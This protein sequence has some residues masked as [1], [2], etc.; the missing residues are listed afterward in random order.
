MTSRRRWLELIEDGFTRRKLCGSYKTGQSVK[1]T[2]IKESPNPNPDGRRQGQNYICGATGETVPSLYINEYATH[3][4]RILG[5]IGSR[6]HGKTAYLAALAHCLR[7]LSPGHFKALD[8]SSLKHL[9]AQIQDL[10]RGELPGPTPNAPQRP[11]LFS[12]TDMAPLGGSSSLL[13]Y[14]SSGEAWADAASPLPPAPFIHPARDLL[15]VYAIDPKRP[16]AEIGPDMKWLLNQF[17]IRRTG[18]VAGPQQLVVVLTKADQWAAQLPESDTVALLKAHLSADWR[19]GLDDPIHY[20]QRLQLVS[21]ALEAVLES[22]YGGGGFLQLARQHFPLGMQLTAVS[23]LGT[24]PE[25]TTNRLTEGFSPKRVLDPLLW[26]SP[27]NACMERGHP[28]PPRELQARLLNVFKSPRQTAAPSASKLIQRAGILLLGLLA[29]TLPAAYLFQSHLP[30][31]LVEALPGHRPSGRETLALAR[32]AK[33]GDADALRRLRQAAED[34]LAPAQ[35]ELSGLLLYGTGLPRDPEQGA[36][37]VRKA[38]AQGSARGHTYLSDYYFYGQGGYPRDMAQAV[39]HAQLAAKARDPLGLSFLGALQ[40]KA[41]GGLAWDE[42]QALAYVREAAALS[43]PQGWVNLANYYLSGSAGVAKNIEE[44]R[45]L[46]NQAVAENEFGAY[47]ILG[48][49]YLDNDEPARRDEQKALD[50]FR[51]G[52]ARNDPSCRANLAGAYLVGLYGLPKDEAKARQIYEQLEREGIPLV[53]WAYM[54]A[55]GLAGLPKDEKRALKL[56]QTAVETG[57]TA[58]MKT[59]GDYYLN[60]LAGLTADPTEALRWFRLAAERGNASAEVSLG[61]M[62]TEGKGLPKDA[63]AAFQHYRK[64]ADKGDSEG[65]RGVGLAYINGDGVKQDHD[66]GRRW[67]EKSLALGCQPCKNDL[68]VLASGYLWGGLGP[69]KNQVKAREILE[70]LYQQGMPTSDYAYLLFNGLGGV[71]QDEVKAKDIWQGLADQGDA[72]SMTLIGQLYSE[73]KGGLVR[74]DGKAIE[75]WEKASA[76]NWLPADVWL[77]KMAAEGR[78]GL[79]DLT[80]A[81]RF[82]LKAAKGGNVDGME[83]YAILCATGQ[84]VARD[85]ETARLWL[86]EALAKGSNNAKTYLDQLDQREQNERRALGQ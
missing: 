39:Q 58:A 53:D 46:A 19:E 20:A 51:L 30:D 40:S 23:A 12:L 21:S 41:V 73:G 85:D 44:A 52:A 31:A 36:E 63:E 13:I 78:G 34:G 29:V 64:A 56:L 45:R 22:A 70:K 28:C 11:A 71:D 33:G 60:G 80:K 62:A 81:A 77:G 86:K 27:A 8:H 32:K 50:Y 37:W 35:A 10:E 15:F 76:L 25:P 9:D 47:A 4:P 61:I 69:P 65:M 18:A 82:Y 5:V 48:Y 17:L 79:K 74:N 67:L 26:I 75:W 2:T 38:V 83:Q 43:E 59:L 16:A 24:A 49:S 84:G 7:Q 72:Q 6:G 55:E 42:K 1:A 14:D 68:K 66:E 54:N 3:P 57:D